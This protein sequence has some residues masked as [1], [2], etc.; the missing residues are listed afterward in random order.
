[1]SAGPHQWGSAP[2]EAELAA[3]MRQPVSDNS[4]HAALAAANAQFER[5]RQYLD[6]C[7][8]TAARTGRSIY[9]DLS[10]SVQPDPTNLLLLLC[11]GN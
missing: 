7:M 10:A 4:V 2:N 3:M 8:V 1:M 5:Q 9:R 6:D 11:H